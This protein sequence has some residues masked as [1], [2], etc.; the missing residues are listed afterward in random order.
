[1]V[2]TFNPNS[3]KEEEMDLCEFKLNLMYQANFRT[4]NP[5]LY[6]EPLSLKSN[7]NNNNNNKCF[8]KIKILLQGRTGI[9]MHTTF[10]SIAYLLKFQ[11]G[12]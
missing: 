6:R 10:Y 2:H 4:S 9:F 3:Q 7:K 11:E 12:F 5:G 8:M 1:M